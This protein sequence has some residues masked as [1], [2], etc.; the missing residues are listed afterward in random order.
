MAYH[1]FVFA[2]PTKSELKVRWSLA[3]L[4]LIGLCASFVHA[5]DEAPPRPG[6]KRVQPEIIKIPLKGAGIFGSDLAMVTHLY[7]PAG[8]GAFP[9]V[10]FSHGRAP[11]ISDRQKLTN[12]VLIGHANFWLGKGF[13]VVAPIRPGYGQSEGM[14]REDAGSNWR[15]GQCI[16]EP[17]FSYLANVA[18]EAVF[19][20]MDW[21]KKQP[22]VNNEKI[23]LVGV[24]VGGLTSAAVAAKGPSGVIGYI[25]FSGGAGGSPRESPGK[26]CK[27]EKLTQLYGEFGKTTHVP[28]L[29]LYAENDLYWG[30]DAPK[31][32]HKAFSANATDT[33]FVMTTP[34]PG[35]DGHRLLAVGGKL[36][37]PHVNAFIK[38]IGF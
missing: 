36:W 6:D 24:S 35:D 14:D 20:T 7:K 9:L 30:P 2:F 32:W 26:S 1:N 17:D 34:V 29:W 21:A 37:S 8:D 18:G 16:G 38:D 27:P 10:I 22:W 11:E 28:S 23:L 19:A 31:E 25:N 5:Q 3:V 33:K 15:R 13:G 12:P 4:L